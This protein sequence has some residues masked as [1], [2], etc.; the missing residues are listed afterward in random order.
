MGMDDI[1]IDA[2]YA[3]AGCFI[4]PNC[5][6][7][8]GLKKYIKK[9]TL[10][11]KRCELCGRTR[12]AMDFYELLKYAEKCIYKEYDRANGTLPYDK[13][14]GRYHGEIFDSEELLGSLFG[15]EENEKFIEVMANVLGEDNWCDLTEEWSHIHR[16][17]S[18]SWDSFKNEILRSRRY[19]FLLSSTHDSSSIP[20]DQSFKDILD[21]I[22]Y[23]IEKHDLIRVVKE[24]NIFVRARAKKPNKDTS[25]IKAIEP[26]YLYQPFNDISQLSSPPHEYA[27]EGRMNPKGIS[28]FYCAEKEETCLKEIENSDNVSITIAKFR[29]VKKLNVLDLGK[30]PSTPSLFDE[31]YE[32]RSILIFLNEFEYDISQK[33]IPGDQIRL[34][35]IPTQIVTEYFRYYLKAKNG[36]NIDGI[37]YRSSVGTG[38]NYV[39]FYGPSAFKGSDS[40]AEEYFELLPAETKA[41][42]LKD[43]E[44]V[45]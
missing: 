18:Y 36:E 39:F 22:G 42:K 44:S 34:E 19:T 4:C 30:I 15:D 16:P 2:A 8:P 33:T 17:M 1:L 28:M 12:N 5:V 38:Y 13:E 3:Y 27:M 45:K 9:R 29:N 35:Y 41:I 7:E 21:E 40:Y 43:L 25:Y 23:F 6:K 20:P 11:E 24:G 32:D 10:P 31:E 14:E 26:D 37:R